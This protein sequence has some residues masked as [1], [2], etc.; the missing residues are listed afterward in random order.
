MNHTDHQRRRIALA[1]LLVVV[2]A[3]YV[4]LGTRSY[5]YTWASGS[6]SG[7][8][9]PTSHGAAALGIVAINLALSARLATP[10]TPQRGKLGTHRVGV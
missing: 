2:A 4:V 6:E 10:G 7:A 8:Y 3:G 9:V 1:T 5:T